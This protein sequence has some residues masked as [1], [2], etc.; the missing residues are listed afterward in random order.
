MAEPFDWTSG[1][2]DLDKLLTRLDTYTAQAA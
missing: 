1:R 2:D